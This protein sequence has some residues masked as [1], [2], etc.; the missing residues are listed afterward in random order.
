MRQ[1]TRRDFAERRRTRAGTTGDM[2][3]PVATTSVRNGRKNTYERREK[4][5]ERIA[6]DRQADWQGRRVLKSSTRF[7][8]FSSDSVVRSK[9]FTGNGRRLPLIRPIG[10][11]IATLELALCRALE[12]LTLRSNVE[13]FEHSKG[14]KET[15]TRR[16]GFESRSDEN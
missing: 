8:P 7:C 13:A 4:E 16:R 11:G 6:N 2:C 14:G 10:N 12:L 15:R 3:I 5:R 9:I 1:T